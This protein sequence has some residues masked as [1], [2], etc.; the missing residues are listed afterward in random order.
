MSGPWSKPVSSLIATGILLCTLLILHVGGSQWTWA[1]QTKWKSLIL[2]AVL[3]LVA[4]PHQTRGG[5]NSAKYRYW[6]S[7]PYNAWADGIPS[8]RDGHT[9]VR[10]ADGLVYMFGGQARVWTSIM[11]GG[12]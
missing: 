10:G 6:Y 11:S 1:P 12:D 2:W 4:V 3:A 5:V 8:A 9:M 7:E